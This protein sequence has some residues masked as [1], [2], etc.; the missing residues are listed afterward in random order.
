MKHSLTVL[1]MTALLAS[2]RAQDVPAPPDSATDPT[3]NSGTSLIHRAAQQLAQQEPFQADLRQRVNLFGQ[4]LVGSGTYLQK[5]SPRGLLVRLDWKIPIADRIASSQQICDGRFLWIRR[6]LLDGS[7]LQRVDLDRVRE[8]LEQEP[9]TGLHQASWEG[10]AI[11]GLPRLLDSLDEYFEFGSPRSAALGGVPVWVVEGAWM[12]RIDADVATDAG[13]GSTGENTSRA[14]PARMSHLPTHVRVVIQQSNW[15]LQRIEYLRR[16]SNDRAEEREGQTAPPR[17]I[18]AIDV[19]GLST[20]LTLDDGLFVCETGRQ[21]I[22]DYT[23]HYLRN[24][25]VQA[26]SRRQN[27]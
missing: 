15:M 26:A 27:R 14:D 16:K 25:G 1:F 5:S 2:T 23:D 18:A 12:P 3:N 4:S 17:V 13:G 11:V 19:V 20:G 22:A 7:M 21:E 6:D 9:A 24:L 8:A 10:V